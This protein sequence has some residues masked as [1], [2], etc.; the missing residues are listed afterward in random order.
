MGGHGARPWGVGVG[1]SYEVTSVSLNDLLSEYGAPQTVDYL[2]I[3]TEGTE[4]EILSATD[5]P[6]WRFEVVTVEHNGEPHRTAIREL[7]TR[8]GY[9]NILPEVSGW[10]DWYVHSES[11]LSVPV[12]QLRASQ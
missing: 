6:K 7:M 12:G 2:S 10:D 1:Q 9:M 5:F 4:L 3:D 11:D 8:Q